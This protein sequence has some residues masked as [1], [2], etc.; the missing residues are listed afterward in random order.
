LNIAFI[1]HKYGV[2]LDDPCCYPLGAMYISAVLKAKGHTVKVLNYNLYD[3]DLDAELEGVDVALFTGFEEFKAS[4]RRD[5][6]KCREKGIRTIVGGALATFTPLEMLRYVDTVVTGEGEGVI[7]R[8]LTKKGIVAGEQVDIN[9]LPLPDYEGFGIE[10]YHRRHQNRYMGVL[11]SRGCP[12]AC[13]FCA[14]TCRFQERELDSVFSEIDLYRERYGIDTVVFNDNTLNVR[15]DRFMA[16]CAGMKARG[17]K[18]GA[19]IR[20]DVWDREMT[21]AAKVS[22]C[23]YFVVGVESFNQAKLEQMHKRITVKQIT[24]C[25]DLLEQYNIDYHGNILFGFEG[26]TYEDIIGQLAEA[27]KGY[28]IFPAMVQPFVGTKNGHKRALSPNEYGR[29]DKMFREYIISQGKYSYP[30]VQAVNA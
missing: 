26:E 20:C 13:T 5:A 19:A 6:E 18:W 23:I 3:Y 16:I 10:E 8:A 22:G 7:E 11:T 2:P 25:L 24:D 28:K 14:S 17:L 27:P 15:R 29:L 30:D 4:I 9:S 12:F 21:R 1:I